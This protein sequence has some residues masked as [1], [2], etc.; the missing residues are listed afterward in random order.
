MEPRIGELFDDYLLMEITAEEDSVTVY[1]AVEL[2][3]ED[4]VSVHVFKPTATDEDELAR[5]LSGDRQATAIQHPHVLRVIETGQEGEWPF[6][7][8]QYVRGPTLRAVISEQGRLDPK[9]AATIVAQ[10][11]DALDAAHG[12]Q[13]IHRDVAPENILVGGSLEEPHAY[14][15]GFAR[16]HDR[17][18]SRVTQIG[19]F[20]GVSS[21]VSPEAVIDTADLDSRADVYS[22]GCVLYE[23]LT[24]SVPFPADSWIMG[25]LARTSDAVPSVLDAVP[26]LDPRW[27]EVIG[28][29][30][31]IDPDERF[32][33]A[34]E[35]G[36]AARE[37]AR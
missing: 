3:G 35:L 12:L 37:L 13:L 2:G 8:T 36:V 9:L 26:E 31:A 28:A 21:Y 32:Q 7:V 25:I 20:A 23:C 22:L 11:A 17:N 29:A 14:L 15:T 10:V 33:T 6:L 19:T 30:T 5:S 24:G 27:G 18:L 1:R 16:S 34:R 4:A